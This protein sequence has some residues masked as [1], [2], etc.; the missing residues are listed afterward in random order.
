MN[1]MYYFAYG[2]NLHPVRLQQRVSSAKLIAATCVAGYQLRF[3]AQ[4]MD[5]SAKCNIVV[6]EESGAGVWGAIYEIDNNQHEQLKKYAGPA[7]ETTKLRIVHEGTEYDCRTYVAKPEHIDNPLEPF[8]WYRDMVYLGAQYHHFPN[9]YNLAIIGIGCKEDSDEQRRKLNH[10]LILELK[11][12][13]QS[14]TR[15]AIKETLRIEHV[16]KYINRVDEIL[17][18]QY[19]LAEYPLA[20]KIDKV[21]KYF[22]QHTINALNELVRLQ[23]RLE[24]QSFSSNDSADEFIGKYAE[25][26]EGLNRRAEQLAQ[27]VPVNRLSKSAHQVADFIGLLGGIVFI[28][29]FIVGGTYYGYKTYNFEGAFFAFLTSFVLSGVVLKS[30]RLL[31]STMGLLIAGALELF[32]RRFVINSTIGFLIALSFFTYWKLKGLP[33][34]LQ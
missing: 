16:E 4:G 13:N 34:F 30:V 12:H 2:S 14:Q 5:H 24:S 20:K 6:A 32:F 15:V 7:Y 11:K 9:K 26:V 17:A 21:A 19:S 18:A 33:V 23:E 27:I 3:H 8:E 1:A 29:G 28:S 31:F 10:V 22:D 25:V